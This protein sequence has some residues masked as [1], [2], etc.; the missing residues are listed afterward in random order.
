M[1][2]LIVE[3][4]PRMRQ[5][6]Q[7]LLK[8]LPISVNCA[9]YALDAVAKAQSIQPELVLMDILL[10]ERDGIELTRQFLDEGW[11][12]HVYIVTECKEQRFRHA[13]STAGAERYFL[14]DNLIEVRNAVSDFLLGS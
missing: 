10:P 7:E 13:A 4:N 9:A 1:N 6:L 12:D 14:K 5:M 2:L 3:D 11:V 8:D